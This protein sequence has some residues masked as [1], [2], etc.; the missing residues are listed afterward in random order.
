MVAYVL[1]R[2]FGIPWVADYRDEWSL[3]T[4]LNWPTPVHRALGRRIDRLVTRNADRVVTTSPAHTASFARNFPS[5]DP[6]KYATVPNGFDDELFGPVGAVA[7]DRPQGMLICHVGSLFGWRNA[8]A[9]IEALR[10]L[11]SRRAL[12]GSDIALRFVGNSPPLRLDGLPAGLVQSTGYVPHE[13]AVSWLKTADVLLLVNTES[14]NILAKTFEYLA[15][16]RPI[17]ALTVEGPTA[18]LIRE[19]DAG[20]IVPPDDIGRIEQALEELHDGRYPE[21]LFQTRYDRATRS[22]LRFTRPGPARVDLGCSIGPRAAGRPVPSG[23]RRG[24]GRPPAGP[25]PSPGGHAPIYRQGP[26]TPRVRDLE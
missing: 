8:D 15:T 2:R 20:V 22:D 5:P 21:T 11:I 16:G 18:E 4:V 10:K 3:R 26:D 13:L 25:E 7:Q 24:R 12:T 6:E 14:T 1:A 19:H 17:L 9:F 23:G